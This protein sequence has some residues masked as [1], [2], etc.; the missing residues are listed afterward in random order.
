[1]ENAFRTSVLFMNEENED[2]NSEGPTK[3][4]YKEK[5]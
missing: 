3:G 4:K 2:S 1:M 5:L